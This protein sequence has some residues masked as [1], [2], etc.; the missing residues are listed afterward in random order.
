MA[1]D[2]IPPRVAVLEQIARDT[3]ATLADIRTDNRDI[4]SEARSQFRWTLGIIIVVLL[5]QAALWQQ[6]GRID[7]R[8][9]GIG[10]QLSDIATTLH[11]KTGG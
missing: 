5:A 9:D 2:T 8:L 10:A 1:D 7:G 4:R 6:V 3:A 11:A